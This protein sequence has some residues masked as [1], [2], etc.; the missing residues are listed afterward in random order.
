MKNGKRTMKELSLYE[1]Q[2][3][4]QD[5]IELF[6]TSNT[7]DEILTKIGQ[8]Y[9]FEAVTNN[10]R[11]FVAKVKREFFEKEFGTENQLRRESYL[12]K[13]QYLLKIAVDKAVETRST[14][15]AKELI[16]SMVKLEGLLVEKVEN[17]IVDD[18]KI[19]F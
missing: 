12:A 15:D 16:D 8:K 2:T 17:K 19:E 10:M 7:T 1:R 6:V 13:Y 4:K 18:F 11:S 14:K 5:I 3:I 9:D